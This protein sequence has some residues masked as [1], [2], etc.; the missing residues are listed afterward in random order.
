MRSKTFLCLLAATSVAA[1]AGTG[2]T[3]G[4]EGTDGRGSAPIADATPPVAWHAPEVPYLP[5]S[6]EFPQ[7]G[8]TSAPSPLVPGMKILGA[9]LL[10]PTIRQGDFSPTT[11]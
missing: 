11:R 10:E 2:P 1:F 3:I 6:E 5:E 9:F 8:S 7:W 4:E